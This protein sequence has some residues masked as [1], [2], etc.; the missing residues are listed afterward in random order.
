MYTKFICWAITFS[1]LLSACGGGSGSDSSRSEPQDARLMLTP[2]VS[3]T[4]TY[5]GPTERRDITIASDYR[6]YVGTG[7]RNAD[8]I[9]TRCGSGGDGYLSDDGTVC[10]L[11]QGRQLITSSWSDLSLDND[12]APR[13]RSGRVSSDRA[14][15]GPS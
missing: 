10:Q 9:W 14:A 13:I 11:L 1:A 6:E 8:R 3:H 5:T 7:V 4:L 2:P 12:G 15:R